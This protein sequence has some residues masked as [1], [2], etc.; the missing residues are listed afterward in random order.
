MS[1]LIALLGLA[2]LVFVAYRGFSVIMFAPVAAM[3]P[4]LL[5]QPTAIPT[6]FTDLFM[7]K[8][9]MFIKLYFPIFLLGALFGKLI[10]LSGFSKSIVTAIIRLIGARQAG[11]TRSHTERA[12]S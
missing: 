12:R 8:A 11:D 4:V 7:T 6:V 2:F 5:T 10:E 9:V 3:L 1:V